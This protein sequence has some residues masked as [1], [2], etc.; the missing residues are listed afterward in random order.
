VKKPAVFVACLLFLMPPYGCERPP[1][2]HRTETPSRG[3]ILAET[4]TVSYDTLDCV[5]RTYVKDGRVDYRELKEN[6][7]GLIAFLHEAASVTK[8]QFDS[9]SRAQ[10]KAFLINLYNAATLKMIVDHY[11]ISS[12]KKI[13]GWVEGPWKQPVVLLWGE[14]VTLDFVENGLLRKMGD[15]RVHFAIVCA[16]LGCP[17]LQSFAYVPGKLDGQ[18]DQAAREFL[19]DTNKNRFDAKDRVIVLSPIFEWFGGDFQSGSG[20]VLNFVSRYVPGDEAALASNPARPIRYSSYDWSLNDD[21]SGPAI[22]A[23]RES[24]ACNGKS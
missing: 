20:S 7:S 3:K 24:S 23:S 2:G 8:P 14:R 10:Q 11:P 13:A 17:K 9:W 4:K 1:R 16:S 6:P 18:L 21:R 22:R 5:L 15:P 19:A 12:I